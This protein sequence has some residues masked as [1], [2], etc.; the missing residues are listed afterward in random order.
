MVFV[1]SGDFKA[2]QICK[3]YAERSSLFLPNVVCFLDRA[4]IVNM[5][6][7][8]DTEGRESLSLNINPEFNVA[9]GHDHAFWLYLPIG[10]SDHGAGARLG[11]LL[12]MLSE[13]L[14]YCALMPPKLFEY[15]NRFFEFSGRG[16][17]LGRSNP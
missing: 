12:F 3:I 11:Y 14:K 7:V 2:G 4:V 9:Q 15:Y 5:H 16:V 6:Y 10:S 1:E 8:K 17:N 13:H